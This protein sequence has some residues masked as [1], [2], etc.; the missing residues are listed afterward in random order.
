MTNIEL[1]KEIQELR[2]EVERLKAELAKAKLPSGGGTSPFALCVGG[3]TGKTVQLS[4]APQI[5]FG[6]GGGGGGSYGKKSEWNA[7]GGGGGLG[8]TTDENK[9]ISPQ[10]KPE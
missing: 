6:G 8:F 1:E 3:G 5:A 7:T 9:S 10:G 4:A 2:H